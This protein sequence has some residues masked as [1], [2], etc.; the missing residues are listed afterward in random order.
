MTAAAIVM[1]LNQ[2][3]RS[4]TAANSDHRR[5]DEQKGPANLAHDL[6][7]SEFPARTSDPTDQALQHE[8]K[9]LRRVVRGLIETISL[10]Q[11]TLTAQYLAGDISAAAKEA[12]VRTGASPEKTEAL[13]VERA[14]GQLI[15]PKLTFRSPRALFVAA[16]SLWARAKELGSPLDP[17][18]EV[19]LRHKL[20]KS[21]LAG[22]RYGN[23]ASGDYRRALTLLRDG[24]ELFTRLSERSWWSSPLILAGAAVA[25]SMGGS[26]AFSV[27]DV[28]LK[29]I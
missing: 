8:E 5:S 16:D 9:N 21:L 17:T 10:D 18:W 15:A 1:L 12:A 4:T 29:Q 11:S 19:P 14:I 28:L 27:A 24:S 26:P 6:R 23:D 25:R 2:A 3:S 22:T 20:E 7:R 13:L